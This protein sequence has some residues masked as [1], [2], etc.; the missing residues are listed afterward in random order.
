MK[1]YAVTLLISITIIFILRIFYS[2]SMINASHNIN[3]FSISEISPQETKRL[4]YF[5]LIGA[6]LLNYLIFHKHILF[7]LLYCLLIV[8]NIILIVFSLK[9]F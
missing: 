2:D 3:I 7:K 6:G 4:V 1:P 8:I 5:Y 9:Q